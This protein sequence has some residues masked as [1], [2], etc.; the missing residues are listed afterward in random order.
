K[1]RPPGGRRTRRAL[2]RHLLAG[3]LVAAR[4]FYASGVHAATTRGSSAMPILLTERQL[5]IVSSMAAPLQ[6]GDRGAFLADAAQVIGGLPELGDG[7]IQRALVPI[8]R[9]YFHPPDLARSNDVSK[10]R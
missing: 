3:G 1:A 9:K 2:R 10:Y 4:W 7:A 5:D 6:P 8:Q